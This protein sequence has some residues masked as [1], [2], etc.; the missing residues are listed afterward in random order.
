MK[1]GWEIETGES[2]TY[3][4]HLEVTTNKLALLTVNFNLISANVGSVEIME[5][6]FAVVKKQENGSEIACIPDHEGFQSVCLDVWVLQATYSV[7]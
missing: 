7:Y 3:I 1:K 4:F 2:Y 6:V 5:N